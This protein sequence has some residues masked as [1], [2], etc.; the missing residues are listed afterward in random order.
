MR[1]GKETVMHLTNIGGFG[2]VDAFVK[3]KLSLLDSSDRS[4]SALYALM[5][6]ER[7]NVMFE[8]SVGYRIEKTTYGEC[9]DRIERK[10]KT[11]NKI[12]G[13]LSH[14]DM[15]GLYMD[16]SL[17]WIESF[18]CIL[19][20]GYRP[21]LMNVRLD[22]PTLESVIAD[23][24]VKAVVSD[25]TEF[26]VKI[27][28]AGDIIP[29]DGAC[30]NTDFGT[31]IFL[32]SSGTSAKI[33]VCAYSAEEFYW[34][35]RDSYSIITECAQM[36]KHYDGELKQLTFLPFCHIFGLVAVYIWFAFFSRTFVELNDMSPSTI[37]NTIRRHKVT[38]IF[39]VPLFWNKVYEQAIAA[40]NDRGEK[41]K[42]KFE[43]GIKLSEKLGAVPSLAKAFRKAA[44][45]EVRGN[46]FGE[47]VQFM[48][49]GGSEIKTEVIS[50]FNNIG[51]H[52]A[53]GYG[54]TEI[55]ITSV[56]LSDNAA[57][58][59]SRSVGKPMSSIEYSLN[60]DGELLVRGKATAKYIIS[61]GE[62]TDKG[63]WFNTHDLAENRDGRW[64]IL[65]RRDDLVI[66]PTGE[67]L[68]PNIVEPVLDGIK[69]LRGA[70]L[71]GVKNDATVTPTLII[72]AD[73]FISEA[74]FGELKNEV[75]E[76]LSDAHLDAQIGKI[77]YTSSSLI[78][79]TEIKLNR[80]L[81]RDGY[82]SGALTEIS[83]DEA[84]REKRGDRIT[85]V[86]TDIFSKALGREAE[87][88]TYTYDF[89]TDGGGTSLDYFAAVS[90]LNDEFGIALPVAD[91]RSLSTVGE[92][93]DYIEGQI[94]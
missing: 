80:R 15:V 35:V 55:G 31:E 34:Q 72:S 78:K 40:I 1:T 39:A 62:R 65:G 82:L 86:I 9:F 17:E 25:G 28:K 18:W 89:F 16:N 58:R 13:E 60:D 51:Y 85:K 44:F 61:G 47:S 37:V 94:N 41:T 3:S 87:E 27:V 11:L 48:I 21:L 8:R 38:H 54:M 59:S 22:K 63:G 79:G 5:F 77:F 45:R 30:G 19:R 57:V 36:K 6:S 53:D 4:F 76:R 29:A 42:A 93:H 32:M 2:N 52:L 83:F 33:K 10:A 67:N 43:K 49:T 24:G 7:E 23:L 50:F 12:L 64:Y 56:E 71:I 66:S 84:S 75:R 20:A 74:G 14:D 46:M 88:I 90:M 91:G 70:C 69:G 92:I 73:G 68:N 26:S 81:V